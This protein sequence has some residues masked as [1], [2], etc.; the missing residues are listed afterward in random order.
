[1]KAKLPMKMRRKLMTISSFD[2]LDNSFDLTY[3]Y[4]YND[5]KV[6]HDHNYRCNS[7]S[8]SNNPSNT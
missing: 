5:T 6:N 4:D 8:N 2:I 3:I 7:N 1:M